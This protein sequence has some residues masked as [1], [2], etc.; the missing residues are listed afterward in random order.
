M[1]D[2]GSVVRDVLANSALELWE[3]LEG[4]LRLP[5]GRDKTVVTAS[6]PELA[7]SWRWT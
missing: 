3:I 6:D 1:G 4:R 7:G 5:I 2:K